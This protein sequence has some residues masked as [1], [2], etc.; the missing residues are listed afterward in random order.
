MRK[1]VRSIPNF[2]I[3]QFPSFQSL[4]VSQLPHFH[5]MREIVREL[6]AR[7]CSGLLD[8]VYPPKCL[9]CGAWLE[10]GCLCPVCIRAISPLLPPYCDR[11]GVPIPADRQVCTACEAGPEPP[12][13][14]SQA[15]GAYAGALRT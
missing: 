1:W 11:C 10:G 12:F 6:L 13:D 14:W 2:L 4:C 8:L 15:L 7:V 9:V 3:S 5:F